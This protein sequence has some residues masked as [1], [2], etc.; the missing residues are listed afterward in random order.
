MS[1]RLLD[2]AKIRADAILEE[3]RRK[4]EEDY[5]KREEVKDGDENQIP[6]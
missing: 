2:E 3:A 1:R 6:S 4:Y 5:A